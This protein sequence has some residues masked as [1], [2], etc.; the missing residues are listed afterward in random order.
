MQNSFMKIIKYIEKIDFSRDEKDV[1]NYCL[2]ILSNEICNV[3]SDNQENFEINEEFCPEE[4]YNFI[5]ELKMKEC[6]GEIVLAIEK[7]DDKY[8]TTLQLFFC[9]EM[10]PNEIAELMGISPKTVYTRLARGKKLLLESLKGAKFN[11]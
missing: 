11:G 3:L 9:K 6:Y 8:C 10:T 5:E 1:K 2:A 4:E 7:L